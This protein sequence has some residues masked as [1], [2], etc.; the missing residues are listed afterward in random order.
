MSENTTLLAERYGQT[1]GAKRLTKSIGIITAA[2]FSVVL[3]L[4][5]WWG[6][7]LE[8][9]GQ[10]NT[11]ELGYVVTSEQEIQ[12]FFEITTPP[13]NE[14]SCAIQ[15]LNGSYGIVGWKIIDIPSSTSWTRTFR[16]TL[17]TSETAVTG[18][19]YECWVA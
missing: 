4:W 10:I 11:R 13:G 17:R 9:P 8:A 3:G 18:L 6:G 16:E 1:P 15:A 12:V 7:V 5:L 2:G 19:L 14:V